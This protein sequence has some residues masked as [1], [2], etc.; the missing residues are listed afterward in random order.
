VD[1]EKVASLKRR[2]DTVDQLKQIVAAIGVIAG[3]MKRLS[4]NATIESARAGTAG[5]GFAV[6]AA[7][8]KSLADAAQGA[9]AQATDLLEA[10][11]RDLKRTV[12]HP[13][14]NGPS[15]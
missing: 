14:T 7:E 2:T 5:R 10:R 12:G 8:M 6:V 9:A 11:D 3:T 13:Y 4:I 15:L 1:E